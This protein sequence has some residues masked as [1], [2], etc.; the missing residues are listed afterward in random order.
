MFFNTALSSIASASSLFSRVFSTSNG[1]FG[2]SQVVTG[3]L[4][5]DGKLDAVTLNGPHT[6]K[7]DLTV[8][9]ML[10]ERRW[11]VL[12]AGS[13]GCRAVGQDVFA[14]DFNGAG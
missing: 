4:N 1:S 2:T 3:D 8:S 9:A 5:G 11:H 12:Q 13:D 10:G 7:G 6:Y 14:G